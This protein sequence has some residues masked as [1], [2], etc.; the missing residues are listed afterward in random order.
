MQITRYRWSDCTHIEHVDDSGQPMTWIEV[1]D[2]VNNIFD[3]DPPYDC[4]ACQDPEG[5]HPGISIMPRVPEN[6]R[7]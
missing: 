2:P 6:S 4:P 3:A 7:Q 1:K 5:T